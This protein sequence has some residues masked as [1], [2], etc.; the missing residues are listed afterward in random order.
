MVL[1]YSPSLCCQCERSIEKLKTQT[2]K[3]L[4]MKTQNQNMLMEL[5]ENQIQQLTKQVKETVAIDFEMN[6][7]KS[8]FSSAD[9]WNIQRM[10][11]VRSGRRTF[12]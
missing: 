8:N 5:G 2:I 1:K 12:A 7:S 4:V 11:R 3:I 6:T 9:L 10:R